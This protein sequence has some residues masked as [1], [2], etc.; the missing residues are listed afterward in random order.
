MAVDT[1]C[2][3]SLAAV[4]LACQSLRLGESHLALAGGVNTIHSPDSFFAFFK[5][6]MTA[7]DGRCKT[8]D[9]SAD[10]F[11]GPRLRDG[12]AQAVVRC[13]VG[14]RSH[15][16]AHRRSAVVGRRE[17]RFTVPMGSPEAV[18]RRALRV[19]GVEPAAVRLRQAGAG[20]RSA[21]RSTGIAHAVLGQGAPRTYHHRQVVKTNPGH[22]ESAAGMAG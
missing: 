6:G 16:G 4:H 18:I 11:V 8:F 5:W 9:D 19:A 13:V 2:S 12:R 17:Q 15:P 1:A 7:P 21:I 22:L 3:S 14:W 10:G 20:R